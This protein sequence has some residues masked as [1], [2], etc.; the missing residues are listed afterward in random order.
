LET[1]IIILIIAFLSYEFMEHVV[2]PVFGFLARKKKKAF[3]GPERLLGE[4]GEVKEW[5]HK[6]GYVFI[7]GELW[8]AVSDIPLKK[9]DKVI[10]RKMEG[11]TVKV[12][13]ANPERV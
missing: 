3:C 10:I 12:C 5:R 1:I 2:F 9:G 11:L 7:Y 4:V 8:K 13:F 6:E